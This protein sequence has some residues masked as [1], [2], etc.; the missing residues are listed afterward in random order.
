MA[1]NGNGNKYPT[2]KWLVDILLAAV[3]FFLIVFMSN[4]SAQIDK[5]LDKEQYY[6][7]IKEMKEKIDCIYS[8]HLP[9]ELR[10]K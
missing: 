3:A 10:G 5:K 7:D 1:E 6:K 4:I 9:P 2:W 8:W